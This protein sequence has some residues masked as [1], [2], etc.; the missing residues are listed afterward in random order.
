[1][2]V[3][4]NLEKHLG[5]SLSFQSIG[6]R[7]LHGDIT[8]CSFICAKRVNST[9]ITVIDLMELRNIVNGY[10]SEGNVLP[11]CVI[12]TADRK[13]KIICIAHDPHCHLAGDLISLFGKSHGIWKNYE[14]NSIRS[15]EDTVFMAFSDCGVNALVVTEEEDFDETGATCFMEVTFATASDS[16]AF[17]TE[18]FLASISKYLSLLNLNM[19]QCKLYDFQRDWK[20]MRVCISV[21]KKSKKMH[22]IEKNKKDN[23]EFNGDSVR[24]NG[25]GRTGLFLFPILSLVF[26]VI[27]FIVSVGIWEYDKEGIL[28]FFF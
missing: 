16:I 18:T 19:V 6:I 8:L 20:N 2:G 7:P 27:P 11:C 12:A 15:L 22:F 3:V 26:L 4:E 25:K 14:S 10:N 13:E 1:M 24:H 23:S 28:S 21:D 5:Q 9:R 17:N